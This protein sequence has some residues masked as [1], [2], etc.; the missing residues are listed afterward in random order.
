MSE[1]LNKV[2]LIG[3][4][5]DAPELRYTQG[6]QPVCNLRMACTESY[7]DK[8]KVR[9]ERTEWARVTIWGPRGESLSKLLEKGERIYVEG[10]L[11]TSSYDKDGE[12]RYS[13]E[14]VAENVI[15][16]GGKRD[17]GDQR[18]ERRD[19]ARDDRQP[20]RDPPQR[21]ATNEGGTRRRLF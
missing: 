18:E 1:G 15:F 2:M 4:L 10:R 5:G 13:T 8:D 7:L 9:C 11:Q 21:A 17:G 3:N 6:G 16:C 14:V 20:R 12:K 19:S